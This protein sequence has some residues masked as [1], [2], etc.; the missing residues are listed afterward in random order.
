MATA[1]KAVYE[2]GVFKPK[3]PVALEEHAEVEVLIPARQTQASDDPTGWKAIDELI[4]FIKGK[5]G[6]TDVSENHDKYLYDDP[7]E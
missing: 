4:G 2:D 5:G 7:H 6:P 1:I 3:E